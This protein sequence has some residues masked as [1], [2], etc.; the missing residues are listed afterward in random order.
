MTTMQQIVLYRL[1]LSLRSLQLQEAPVMKNMIM[2]PGNRFLRR[3]KEEHPESHVKLR[4]LGLKRTTCLSSWLPEPWK[5][6]TGKSLVR[7]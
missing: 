7:M 1:S 2:K 5:Q 3:P 4:Y 6:K